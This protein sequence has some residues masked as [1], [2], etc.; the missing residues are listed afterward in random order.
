[1]YIAMM[2]QWK[3][4]DTETALKSGNWL[5]HVEASEPEQNYP[6]QTVLLAFFLFSLSSS[7]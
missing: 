1:M 7:P 4:D 6:S 3:P 5:P 2:K